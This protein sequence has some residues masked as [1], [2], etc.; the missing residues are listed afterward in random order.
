MRAGIAALMLLC[1]LMFSG[2]AQAQT[3]SSPLPFD[4][5]PYVS[6]QDTCGFP[7]QQINFPET[8]DSIFAPAVVYRVTNRFARPSANR[9]WRVQVY[10]QYA[11]LNLSVWVC[12]SHV[13]TSL[14]N[15]A[16]A[17][18]NGAGMANTVT[19]P[20]FQ[21]GMHYV[22]VTGNIEGQY[23]YCGPYTLLGTKL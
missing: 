4:A 21:A 23:Q 17:S 1:G 22:V 13:G 8:G 6:Q 5:N 19:V 2:W 11:F 16:D 3:W 9:P 18:D 14:F 20:G 7:P 10:P 15:C 12:D